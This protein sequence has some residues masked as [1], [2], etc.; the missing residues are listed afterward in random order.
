ME[1]EGSDYYLS[2]ELPE[3]PR[4]T[5]VRLLPGFDE[6]LLGYTDRSAA[7][8]EEHSPLVFPGKNGMFLSTIVFDG[9]V[10]GTWK[11]TS[12]AK[13]VTVDVRPFAPITAKSAESVQVSAQEYANFV[14]LELRVPA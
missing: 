13:T 5:P 12:T 11:R 14:G 7:L 3:E 6:Y 2:A 9:A 1:L 10:A 4:A 8:S